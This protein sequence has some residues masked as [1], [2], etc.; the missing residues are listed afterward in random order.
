MLE[1]DGQEHKTH[2]N[3]REGSRLVLQNLTVFLGS[4]PLFI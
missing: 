3:R 4:I 2:V 1:S